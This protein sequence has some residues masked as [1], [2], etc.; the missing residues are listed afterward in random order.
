MSINYRKW[1]GTTAMAAM[2]CLMGVCIP[3]ATQAWQLMANGNKNVNYEMDGL[4]EA[5]LNYTTLRSGETLEIFANAI[6]RAGA[7]EVFPALETMPYGAFVIY[8]GQYVSNDGYVWV[9]VQSAKNISGWVK[10][11]EVKVA[12]SSAG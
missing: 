11:T 7:S 1:V 10:E 9:Y 8:L 4:Q 12:E 5:Y 2:I 6:L 3:D